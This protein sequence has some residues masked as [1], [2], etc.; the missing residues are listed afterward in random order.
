[1]SQ[2]PPTPSV[3]SECAKVI[4]A[5]DTIDSVLSNARLVSEEPERIPERI[6]A[7]VDLWTQ[8]LLDFNELQLKEGYP[9]TLTMRCLRR[10]DDVLGREALPGELFTKNFASLAFQDRRQRVLL[11]RSSHAPFFKG[12]VIRAIQSALPV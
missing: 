8:M 3:K 12:Q 11:P 5:I 6:Q 10:I 4:S 2:H 7:I 9:F 1:M